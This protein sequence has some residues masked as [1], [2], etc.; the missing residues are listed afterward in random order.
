V[1]AARALAAPVQ[2]PAEGGQRLGPLLRLDLNQE[3][4]EE[5]EEEEEGY[6]RDG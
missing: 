3:E 6:D 2:E 4:E 5:E 1:Q